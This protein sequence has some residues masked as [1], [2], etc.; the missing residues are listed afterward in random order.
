MGAEGIQPETVKPEASIEIVKYPGQR[1]PGTYIGLVYS[2]WLRS[3]RYGNDYFRLISSMDY[4]ESYNRYISTVLARPDTI[5]RLATLAVD[6]D[7]VLGF[8]VA[9][10]QILEYVHVHKDQRLQ[11]IARSLVP[12]NIEVVTHLTRTGLTI[13][14]NKCPGWS[15]N[16]FA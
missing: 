4:Y 8:S 6:R 1:L 2:R 12:K 9:R 16:P 10:G 13:W 11:G 7:C 14:A 3:L 15:F 5:V